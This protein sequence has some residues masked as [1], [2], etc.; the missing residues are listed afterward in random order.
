M[1]SSSKARK[2]TKPVASSTLISK[3]D[4][5]LKEPSS[6][7]LKSAETTPKKTAKPVVN[8]AAAKKTASSASKA[9]TS[10]VKPASAINPEI[11]KR[12][13]LKA[14]APAR[15]PSVLSISSDSSVLV[16]VDDDAEDD[17][18]V[19][20]G[21]DD[22]GED[23]E[24]VVVMEDVDNGD[25]ADGDNEMGG[26]I[27]DDNDIEDDN[28]QTH[29]L[30]PTRSRDQ[31]SNIIST[32]HQYS[33]ITMSFKPTRATKI[34]ES[35]KESGERKEPRKVTPSWYPTDE[36]VTP[37][38]SSL[39]P[40]NPTP[41]LPT[42]SSTPA[43]RPLQK[44]GLLLSTD[45][46]TAAAQEDKGTNF[47][48]RHMPLPQSE[49][50][51]PQHVSTPEMLRREIRMLPREP[52]PPTPQY[53]SLFQY[54][55]LC[56][57][58]D[59]T[60]RT[61]VE[62]VASHVEY[63]DHHLARIVLENGELKQRIERLEQQI[64][65]TPAAPSTTK[66]PAP[67]S[68][69]TPKRYRNM[70]VQT[71]KWKE[72]KSTASPKPRAPP[73]TSSIPQHVPTPFP[74]HP[75]SGYP[76][77]MPYP[78][79]FPM[80]MNYPML[81]TPQ[82]IPGPL[83]TPVAS[84]S[85][86]PPTQHKKSK[87]KKT[88]STDEDEEVD[89][90]EVDAP[91]PS[92]K[93]RVRNRTTREMVFDQLIERG[94]GEDDDLND[95]DFALPESPM[96][97]VRRGKDKAS[98]APRPL[99]TVAKRTPKTPSQPGAK[100]KLPKTP[101]TIPAAPITPPASS[102]PSTTRSLSINT[103]P[104]PS[105]GKSKRVVPMSP[106][107]R[108]RKQDADSDDARDVE[109]GDGVLDGC[110]DDNK[111]IELD[112]GL[113][114]EAAVID[115]ED[116]DDS[117]PEPADCTGLTETRLTLPLNSAADGPTIA[118]V[119]RVK[120]T[121]DE[122]DYKILLKGIQF[123]SEDIYINYYNVDASTLQ[124]GQGCYFMLA[125][126]PEHA[127]GIITGVVEASYLYRSYLPPSIMSS[128]S[129]YAPKP[130]HMLTIIPMDPVFQR[131]SDI[132]G[133][134]FKVNVLPGALTAFSPSKTMNSVGRTFTQGPRNIS[135]IAYQYVKAFD[136]DIPIYD[137]RASHGNSFNFNLED[138]RDLSKRMRILQ[139]NELKPGA[140]VAVGHT[141][142]IVLSG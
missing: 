94:F 127:I 132:L 52:P 29:T 68:D 137:G 93:P 35:S 42:T 103:T 125:R 98:S 108:K 83:T 69:D 99:T 51:P 73:Q 110:A 34:P 67:P 63:T 19:I 27:D 65:A 14:K 30:R 3:L 133:H 129:T 109:F 46:H 79:Q 41:S 124:K 126:K 11:G 33:P 61:A 128:N 90:E 120:D 55:R 44:L 40:S 100:L 72:L 43:S 123:K 101:K 121:M 75:Y 50:R 37:F 74:I 85:T 116:E 7:S 84:G 118:D 54:I 23:D 59:E 104:S 9:T 70:A 8:S 15:P 28:N 91:S 66:T 107:S 135:G 4:A 48:V 89:E 97:S 80:P 39:A 111:D 131:F 117:L 49:A 17:E 60:G 92:K 102:T 141:F 31:Q 119:V 21:L 62:H 78:Y 112:T 26:D 113:L 22:G 140:V 122:L 86:T 71:P 13:T 87:K 1:S 64:A 58:A 142:V 88:K 114:M 139:R 77:P 10:K 18:D 136:D 105:K 130:F 82:F 36:D 47:A 106:L 12:A 138:F 20:D 96:Q 76:P 134:T 53:T 32:V 6:P 25:V 95:S 81:M 57:E 115:D 16:D 38:T 45:P 5:V 2:V 24:E 56:Y